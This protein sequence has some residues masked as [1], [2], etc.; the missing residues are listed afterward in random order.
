MTFNFVGHGLDIGV[1]LAVW[2]YFYG[3]TASYPEYSD[4]NAFKYMLCG[5]L[6]GLPTSITG[7]PVETAKRAYYADK[8]WP[9]EYRRNYKSPL[10]ALIR[11]PF[12]EGPSYLLKGGLPIVIRDGI[13]FSFFFSIYAWLKNK[14]FF[15]WVY[16]DF[17]YEWIKLLMMTFSWG[18]GCLA[19][20]PAYFAREMVDLWP[21][22]RGGHCTWNN[23]YYNAIMW[24]Y[25]N[26][27]L[28]FTNYFAGYTN[29]MV[30]KGIPVFIAVWMAD[31][32]GM[33]TNVSDSHYAFES[34]WPTLMENS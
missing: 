15:L 30:K 32:I 27:D 5:I 1:K 23:S 26:Q 14:L 12:E 20:Y 21:K 2:Q 10:N 4:W 3:A 9:L 13:F 24:A 8:T 28:F 29:Y 31:N 33:F 34:V 22:E 17:S 25:H 18:M 19:S 7:V 11:I 6:A 16:N